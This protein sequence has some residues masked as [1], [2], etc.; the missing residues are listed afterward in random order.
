[1]ILAEEIGEDYYGFS[2]APDTRT[3]AQLLL[4][5]ASATQKVAAMDEDCDKA[6]IVGLLRGAGEHYARWLENL[7]MDFLDERV[8]LSPGV[9]LVR[10][11][12]RNDLCDI[13]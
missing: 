8:A 1:V 5:I 3:V 10:Q 6:K 9:S 13:E 12:P 2:P 11:T 7:S 4:H